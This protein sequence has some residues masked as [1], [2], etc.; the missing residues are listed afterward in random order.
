MFSGLMS[1]LRSSK[2]PT[3]MA[4]HNM[5]LASLPLLAI[6]LE[7]T[8]L[9]AK[10]AEITSIGWVGA[11]NYSIDLSTCRYEVI[12][13][14]AVLGQSPVIHGLTSD[15]LKKGRPLKEVVSALYPLLKEHVL[16][17]HNATLDLAALNRAITQCGL[18]S[19]PVTF[20]DT[21][22]LAVYQLKKQ[23]QV[24]PNN[25]A[26]LTVC[27]QRLG[28]PIAPEHNALDDALATLQ[29]LLAQYA[30]LGVTTSSTFGDMKHT[31]A[32]GRKTIGER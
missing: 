18:P 8:S 3:H 10:Q 24:L 17:F 32:I 23:H 30:Q 31:H 9:D 7:L 19:V 4:F 13:T 12:Q 2:V 15:L 21:L 5:T 29:L 22:Q 27:R 14:N 25:S 16:V 20:I 26:T 6:D 1:W 28:L 11:K